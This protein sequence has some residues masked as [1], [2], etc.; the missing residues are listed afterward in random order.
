[1]IFFRISRQIPENSD[2]CRFLNQICENKSEICRKLWILWKLFTI[3]QN[4][5]L[6]SLSIMQLCWPREPRR[7]RSLRVPRI[8]R[9]ARVG[10]K[11]W[12][13]DQPRTYAC[14]IH[15]AECIESE[16]INSAHLLIKNV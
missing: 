1:M 4:Y 16:M 3:I 12:D 2:V 14:N 15:Y 10:G 5:W 9:N 8:P 7:R 6:V 13:T 11:V